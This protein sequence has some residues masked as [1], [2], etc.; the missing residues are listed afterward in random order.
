MI[1]PSLRPQQVDLGPALLF[2]G[3]QESAPIRRKSVG[4]SMRACE[5]G[6]RNTVRPD[7]LMKPVKQYAAYSANALPRYTTNVSPL[8]AGVAQSW[9]G[10]A[11]ITATEGFTDPLQLIP[12]VSL[13]QGGTGGVVTACAGLVLPQASSIEPGT[14]ATWSATLYLSFD[15]STPQ[16]SL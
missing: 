13:L 15:Q 11:I 12:V 16:L 8:I 5:G 7:L 10:S 14:T 1:S 6:W 2:A 3:A 4:N 9:H